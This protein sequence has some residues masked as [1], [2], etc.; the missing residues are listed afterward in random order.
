M[1]LKI[2]PKPSAQF[3]RQYD[4]LKKDGLTERE[5]TSLMVRAQKEIATSARPHEAATMFTAQVKGG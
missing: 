2:A 1:T 3:L 4:T 5:L